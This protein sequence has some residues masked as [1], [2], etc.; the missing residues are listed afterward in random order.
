MT[1][2]HALILGL[3][4]GLTEFLPISST[5]HLIWTST[6]LHLSQSDFQK[7][8]EIIIQSG[9]ILAVLTLYLPT[10]LHDWQLDKKLLASF[11]PTA[12]IGFL[13]YKLIKNSFFTDSNLQLVVFASI[14]ILFILLD[15]IRPH[16]F[17]SK[18]LNDLT[19][20]QAIFVG[21]AQAFA[22]VPGVS[23]AGAV[24]VA[25]LFLNFRRDEAARY[26][27]LLA[28]PTIVAASSLDIYKSHSLIMAQSSHLLPLIIGFI[29]AFISALLVINWFTHYLKNHTLTSFG[30]YRLILTIFLLFLK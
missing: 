9:A 12:I 5:F 21:L 26:S 23:R 14:G 10:L 25:L 13:L 2:I 4:E 22:V 11:I 18:S 20:P 24:I 27:F 19:Y 29:T 8:F 17:L 15:K 6:L 3:I 7:T 16:S 28:L 30:W 1:A